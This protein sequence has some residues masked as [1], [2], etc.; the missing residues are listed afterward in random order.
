MTRIQFLKQQSPL[1]GHFSVHPRGKY[2]QYTALSATIHITSDS[3]QVS[4]LVGD[5][6]KLL[7]ENSIHEGH[8]HSMLK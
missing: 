5:G 3:F 2:I 4:A 8:L 7:Y 6:L 1:V